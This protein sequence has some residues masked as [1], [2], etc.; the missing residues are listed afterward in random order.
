MP[1]KSTRGKRKSSTFRKRKE[2]QASFTGKREQPVTARTSLPTSTTSN[3]VSRA[4]ISEP[5]KSPAVNN[6][7]YAISELKRIG[8][9]T[10]I[11]L[12]IEILLAIMLRSH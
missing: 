6:H 9:L 8:I 7:I 4:T 12:V 3:A 5:I 2:R 11:I 1:N 10:G